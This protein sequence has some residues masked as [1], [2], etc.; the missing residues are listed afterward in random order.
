M[1]DLFALAFAVFLVYEAARLINAVL[2]WLT[3]R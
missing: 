2:G 3:E 1:W